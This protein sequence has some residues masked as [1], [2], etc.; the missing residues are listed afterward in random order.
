[1]SPREQVAAYL[2]G[3]ANGDD[4]S[5]AKVNRALRAI[6]VSEAAWTLIYARVFFWKK[7]LP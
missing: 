1:M 7:P 3:L 2:M 6:E 4:A 5:R